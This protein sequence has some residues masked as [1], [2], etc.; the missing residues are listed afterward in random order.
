MKLLLLTAMI[1]SMTSTVFAHTKDKFEYHDVTFEVTQ[2]DLID[3][4]ADYT[5]NLNVA[6]ERALG[7]VITPTT[8]IKSVVV[9]GERVTRFTGLSLENFGTTVDFKDLSLVE[10]IDGNN[11]VVE[12]TNSQ[13][14]KTDI[15][16][17]W[18]VSVTSL[19]SSPVIFKPSKVTVSVENVRPF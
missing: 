13:N 8:V 1:F 5:L 2:I 15:G 4:R 16:G 7:D 17:D 12:L 11:V 10:A 18:T 6:I 9:E 14:D 19:T 3:F